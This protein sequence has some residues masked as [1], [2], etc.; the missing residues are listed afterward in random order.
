M[1]ADISG[2]E[3]EEYLIDHKMVQPNETE[4]GVPL[5]APCSTE[6][7]DDAVRMRF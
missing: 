4:A 3:V 2:E 5:N 6:Q 7:H 1:L